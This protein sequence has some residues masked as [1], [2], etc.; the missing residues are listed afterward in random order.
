V[1]IPQ[2]KPGTWGTWWTWKGR[3]V[4][5]CPTCGTAACLDHQIA[6]D[7]AVTPSVECAVLRCGFHEQVRLLDWKP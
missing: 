4:V 2:G 1:D 3:V 7:G 6:A 5:A